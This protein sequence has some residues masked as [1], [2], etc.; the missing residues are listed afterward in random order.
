MSI[1]AQNLLA[2]KQNSLFHYVQ[3]D[4]L[5]GVMLCPPV[6]RETNQPLLNLVLEKFRSSAQTIHS[7][8][9]NTVQFKKLN[10]QEVHESLINKS[11][12]AIKEY[13]VLFEAELEQGKKSSVVSLNFW[14]VGRLF[15]MPNAKE[16]YVCYEESA[17]QNMVEI[18]F[19]LA[20]SASG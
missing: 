10:A 15:F 19:R 4:K 6:G 2:G 8:L 3:L 20:L 17:P 5:E 13:G 18:A 9:Q 1:H 14:V 11:L 12:V 7:L 16:V